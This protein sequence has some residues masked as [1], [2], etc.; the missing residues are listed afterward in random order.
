MSSEFIFK[1]KSKLNLI[2]NNKSQEGERENEMRKK[3]N[4]NCRPIYSTSIYVSRQIHLTLV[5]ADNRTT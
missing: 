1:I 5:Y 2:Q 3:Q 4:N